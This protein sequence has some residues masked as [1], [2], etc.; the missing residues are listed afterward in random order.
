MEH[1]IIEKDYYKRETCGS[2]NGSDFETILDLGTVP[3]AGYCFKITTI[4]HKFLFYSN[5]FQL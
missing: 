5:P 4:K 3:L 1:T 2:C